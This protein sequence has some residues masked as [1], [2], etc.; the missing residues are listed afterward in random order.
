MHTVERQAE[1]LAMA[2]LADVPAP[3]LDWV[4]TDVAAFG[5]PDRYAL[6]VAGGSAHR[7]EKRWP[8][9]SFA[10]LARWLADMGIAPVLLGTRAEADVNA[11]IAA[12]CDAAIDLTGRTGFADIV[13][14]ARGAAAAVGNDT[15]P[16]HLVATAGAPSAVLFSQFSD[17]ALCAPRG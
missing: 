4:T 1:Q 14:L 9:G 3:S 6:L 17:P 15:G 5:L 16:M 11:T 13:A 8:V 10:R 7:P 12:F 2:G